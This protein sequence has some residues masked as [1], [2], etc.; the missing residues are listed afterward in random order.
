[1]QWILLVLQYQNAEP[2]RKPCFRAIQL[3]CLVV[4][5]CGVGL[6]AF[7]LEGVS[8]SCV[9]VYQLKKTKEHCLE[10]NLKHWEEKSDCDFAAF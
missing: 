3:L 5:F 4:L 10:I 8:I 2:I 9:F 7:K 1:M 6:A